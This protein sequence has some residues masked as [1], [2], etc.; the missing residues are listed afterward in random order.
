[1]SE[2]I[3]PRMD[4]CI[5]LYPP[6]NFIPWVFSTKEF[7]R[8]DELDSAWLQLC[9][10]CLLDPKSYWQLS[11]LLLGLVNVTDSNK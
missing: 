11:S 8:T 3:N 4:E 9:F 1:M 6:H 5:S 7:S 10:L 2:L